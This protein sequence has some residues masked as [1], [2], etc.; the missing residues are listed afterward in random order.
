MPYGPGHSGSDTT[1]KSFADVK[2]N[3]DYRIPELI[4]VD[5]CSY[6][7]DDCEEACCPK[8]RFSLGAAGNEVPLSQCPMCG[9]E[10]VPEEIDWSMR[11]TRFPFLSGIVAGWTGIFGLWVG[12]YILL[13][14]EI[15]PPEFVAKTV[16]LLFP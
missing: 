16:L 10:T 5:H 11:R 8:M 13:K 12:M 9:H 4:G 1:P 15:L 2:G 14:M 3:C 7:N 6:H